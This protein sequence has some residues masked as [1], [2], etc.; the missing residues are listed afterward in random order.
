[1]IE[2]FKENKMFRVLLGYRIFSGLGGGVFSLFMLLSVH[3]IYQNPVYTGI[4]GF[5]IAAPFIFS[6]AVGPIV[7]KRNK[8]AIMRLTTFIEFAVLAL[9]AFTPLLEQIGVLFMFAVI[10]AFS[11]V[12]VFESPADT[13]LLPQI[14]KSEKILQAN[15]LI[16]ITTFVGGL[17]VAA[18][19]FVALR[20]AKNINFTII[21][22]LSAGF[23]AL[24][25]VYALFLKDPSQNDE[26]A[27]SLPQNYLQDLKEG[28]KFIRHN[29]LLYIIIATVSL[30][31]FAEIAAVNRP[32]FFEY[33]AGAQG[34]IVLAIMGLL[35]GIVASIFIGVFGNKFKVGQ[36]AFILLLIAGAVRI[37]FVQV[38][39]LHFASALIVMILY[40]TFS[41]A[42]GIVFS[43]LKQRIPP[44]DMV[45]RVDTISTTL[46]AVSVAIG[47]VAGGFLGSIVPIVN[48]IFV[49]QGISYAVIG[50]L[51][52]F[53]PSIRK[54]PKTAEIDK[55]EV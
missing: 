20:D 54:L 49:Y 23:L 31:L 25:F 37:V 13:A 35:G 24:A 2:L 10:L 7:D 28:A 29:V 19:L 3:L 55:P 48:H 39:P 16:Q 18:L 50:V 4:A 43:S 46:E 9:L 45:G 30:A 44:K 42:A 26:K 15:S 27:K 36:L 17:A 40:S 53:I 12:A 14:V 38:L 8:P 33:Y 5:L 47:A 22:G 21:F 32:M 51:L 6:F 52:L 11:V 41:T 34:Y 1:M